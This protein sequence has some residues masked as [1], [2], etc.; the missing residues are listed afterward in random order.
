[1]GW[2]EELTSNPLVHTEVEPF[3]Y[4][5]TVTTLRHNDRVIYECISEGQLEPGGTWYM[6]QVNVDDADTIMWLLG[7]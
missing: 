5:R 6:S 3:G 2:Y 7:D 1:M 4:N